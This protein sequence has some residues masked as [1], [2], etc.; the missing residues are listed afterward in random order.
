MRRLKPCPF[1]GGKAGIYEDYI[2]NRFVAKC[3][4]CGMTTLHKAT[5]AEVARDWNR[6]VE[7][8]LNRCEGCIHYDD[9]GYCMNQQQWTGGRNEDA[10]KENG[11]IKWKQ[12]KWQ[13]QK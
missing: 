9:V 3:N 6:R 5:K 12:L 1:C 10:C 11:G 2:G 4:S 7:D 13:I 8:N